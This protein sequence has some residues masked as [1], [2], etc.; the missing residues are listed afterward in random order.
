MKEVNWNI[1]ANKV[2]VWAEGQDSKDPQIQAIML[3]LGLG[4]NAG[5]DD[6]R[7][8]YWTAIRSIG[9]NMDGFPAARKG[10]VSSLTDKQQIVLDAVEQG[11][12][13]AFAAIPTEHHDMLL[14]V[15]VPNGRT[16]GVYADYEAFTNDMKRKAH[17]YM[18]KSIKEQRWDGESVNK[19]GVPQITPTAKDTKKEVKDEQE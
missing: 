19:A 16:G 11:I 12:V 13:N 4:D 5:N 17:N 7:S 8:T 18:M 2:R 1:N 15:I 3:S 6:I 9:S 14:S 10:Q